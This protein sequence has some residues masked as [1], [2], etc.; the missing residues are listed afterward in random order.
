MRMTLRSAC[1]VG[2]FLAEFQLHLLEITRAHHPGQAGVY[3]S[4]H[5][6]MGREILPREKERGVQEKLLISPTANQNVTHH[7][8]S[9][10]TPSATS[11]AAP[12]LD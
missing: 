11:P 5:Q 10:T 6:T 3:P 7:T 8:V 2:F 9:L 1:H 4:L 12:L